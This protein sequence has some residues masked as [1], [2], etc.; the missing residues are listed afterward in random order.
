MSTS[1][2]QGKKYFLISKRDFDE[3]F[4]YPELKNV[5]RKEMGSKQKRNGS[6]NRILT[7]TKDEKKLLKEINEWFKHIKQSNVAISKFLREKSLKQISDKRRLLST[8]REEMVITENIIKEF[9][10]YSKQE[11]S[12]ENKERESPDKKV[13]D[14]IIP[15]QEIIFSNHLDYKNLYEAIEEQIE[16]LDA[17]E[18]IFNKILYWQ[19][20][21]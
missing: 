3:R 18:T 5:K 2:I 6:G 7:W 11:L 9:L 8:Q 14:R 17:K 4:A 1:A 12:I 15:R 10:I 20:K 16:D 21:N 13:I 19:W